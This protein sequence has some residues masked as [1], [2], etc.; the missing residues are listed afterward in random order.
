MNCPK[1]N[2]VIANENINIQKDIAKCDLCN[3]VFTI[4]EIVAPKIKF[5]PNLPPEGTWYTN[6]FE[7][8]IVGSTTRSKAAFFLVPFM[9]VWSGFSLGGIYGTQI[10]SGK[11]NPIF[12]LFGIPFVIGTFVLGAYV[13][14]TIAGKIEIT[15]NNEGGKIFTG[16]GKIGFTKSF[17]WKDINTIEESLSNMKSGSSN[18]YQINLIGQ[19]RI[20]F[21]SGLSDERRYYIMSVLRNHLKNKR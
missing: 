6:D 16:V 18:Y 12:A 7:T 17:L 2:A 10:I 20:S 4:S 19:K 9:M 3:H 11:F 5:D 21:G 8:T 1:C 15:Y 13:I 14:M